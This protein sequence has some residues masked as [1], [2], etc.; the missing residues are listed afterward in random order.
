MQ[1]RSHGSAGMWGVG[2]DKSCEPSQGER[3]G[4]QRE[5]C[6][7]ERESEREERRG[8]RRRGGD[9]NRQSSKSVNEA[10][11]RGERQ[12]HNTINSPESKAE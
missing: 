4:M 9:G 2:G 10:G 11:G 5:G 3:G 1:A 6:V 8:E 7:R 12:K